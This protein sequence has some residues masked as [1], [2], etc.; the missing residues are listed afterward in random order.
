MDATDAG[1]SIAASAALSIAA[2]AARE[3]RRLS[4]GH[5]R[6]YGRARG[7]LARPSE[8]KARNPSRAFSCR[9]SGAAPDQ[10]AGDRGRPCRAAAWVRRAFAGVAA[11]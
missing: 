1:F 11:R 6:P 7:P 9:D 2:R 3:V 8:E 4:G 5:G 10:I